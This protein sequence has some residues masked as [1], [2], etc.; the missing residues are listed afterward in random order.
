MNE[1]YPI[2]V[3]VMEDDI[4]NRKFLS[5]IHISKVRVSDT[6][7]RIAKMKEGAKMYVC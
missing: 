6:R 7:V 5:A 4:F 1:N 2:N 3:Y